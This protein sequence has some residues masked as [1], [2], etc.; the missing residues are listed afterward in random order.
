MKTKHGCH[1]ANHPN[2]TG[3]AASPLAA[4]LRPNQVLA[5]G[6]QPGPWPGGQHV[7]ALLQSPGKEGCNQ[8]KK[9]I[10]SQ[11]PIST[12]QLTTNG[13]WHQFGIDTNPA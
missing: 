5:W 1:A 12:A 2:P 7:R 6:C 13:Q 11:Q 8:Y 3:A 9:E 10:Q 4:L